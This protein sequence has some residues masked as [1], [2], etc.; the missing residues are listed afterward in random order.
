MP[1]GTGIIAI[2]TAT[3]LLT[4]HVRGRSAAHPLIPALWPARSALELQ[5]SH[6]GQMLEA[7]LVGA[8]QAIESALLS[9]KHRFAC[10]TFGHEAEV[11]QGE[12]FLNWQP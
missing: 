9:L 12:L 4:P 6:P 10:L 3:S 5:P 1:F 8:A 7:T 2:L 11:R